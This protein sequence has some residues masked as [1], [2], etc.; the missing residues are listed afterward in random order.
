M[1]PPV[2]ALHGFLGRGADWDPVAAAA[3]RMGVKVPWVGPDLFA[4]E[5]RVPGPEL[6]LRVWARAFA[7]WW[8]SVRP[9]GPPA[10]LA[11]YSLGGRLAA[12]LAR[13]A[14]EL[15]ARVVLVSARPGRFPSWEARFVRRQ[16]DRDWARRFRTWPWESLLA[17]WDEQPVLQGSPRPDRPEAVFDRGRLALALERWSV[18][19]QDAEGR[20]GPAPLH[21]IVGAGDH[22]LLGLLPAVSAGLLTVVPGAGHRLLAEAPEA[23]ARALFPPSEA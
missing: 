5:P 15:F 10:V 21:R 1:N 20:T 7:G 13:E 8:R 16:Q 12:C 2:L 18:A 14:P 23:V 19:R 9:D 11:G 6:P 4:P 3:A 17:A 22:G